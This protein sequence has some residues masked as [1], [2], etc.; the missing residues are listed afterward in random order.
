MAHESHHT[1]SDSSLREFESIHIPPLLTDEE[2]NSDDRQLM[3][4]VLNRWQKVAEKTFNTTTIMM[5]YGY[6]TKRTNPYPNKWSHFLRRLHYL[7]SGG[8]GLHA[9]QCMM[10]IGEDGY[11]EHFDCIPNVA[12]PSCCAH[13]THTVLFYLNDNDY[14]DEVPEDSDL[15]GGEFFFVDRKDLDDPAERSFGGVGLAKQLQHTLRVE[16]KCGNVALFTGDARNLHGTMPIRS[17][18]RY[19]MP[20]WFT[21]PAVLHRRWGEREP[22]LENWLHIM[23]DRCHL[24]GPVLPMPS[25]F[26]QYEGDCE[27]LVEAI[28]RLAYDDYPEGGASLDILDG[29]GDDGVDEREVGLF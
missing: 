19:A 27:G 6:I 18:A 12:P 16:P 10:T 24:M 22:N 26:K 29:D 4:D 20:M 21:D 28:K 7:T 13:R 11:H 1:W 15:K 23:E 17:G 9:D 2:V 3:K 25:G 14:D 5:E 8:H